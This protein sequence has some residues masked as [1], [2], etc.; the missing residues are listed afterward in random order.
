[1]NAYDLTTKVNLYTQIK[2]SDFVTHMYSAF[3]LS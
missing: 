1:M 3:Q 2:Y